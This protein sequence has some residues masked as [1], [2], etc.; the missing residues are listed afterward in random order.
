VSV[1]AINRLPVA[2]REQSARMAIDG[3]AQRP[4]DD[5]PVTLA[6]I[7]DGYLRTLQIPVVR[8]RGIDRADVASNRRVALVSETAAT[9][10]WPGTDPIGGRIALDRTS[11]PFEWLEV[12]GV[13]GDVRNSDV[14]QGP[15]AQVYVP[16]SF[17]PPN[18]LSFIVRTANEEPTRLT[19][20]IR[21]TV[22]RL[23]R[24]LPVYGVRTMTQV[25]FEDMAGTFLVLTVLLTIA[26]VALVL[27]TAGIYGLTSYTVV[28]RTREIG[29]R[30]ALG[31]TPVAVM[32]MI[33][34]QGSRPVA[35]GAA[36][37]TATA[38]ALTS[39]ASAAITEVNF[40]D[41]ANYA[42]VVAL[43]AV[44]A[45]AATWLPARRATRV[46]PAIALRG[47]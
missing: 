45:L 21:A 39:F 9:Y 30:M 32:Q 31:A 17:R 15:A 24:T 7:T 22:S 19:P 27:A 40:F 47:E 41:P 8:G 4:E 3:A 1:A 6:S 16:L 20:E 37:G 29:I 18:T 44:V 13:V 34:V 5:A 12:V 11:S 26:G 33:V 28:Q 36:A 38:I 10:Y 2:D 42:T 23:D 35:V 25:L 46:A 43:L 14:D